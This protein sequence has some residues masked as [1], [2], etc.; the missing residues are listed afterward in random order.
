M[1]ENNLITSCVCDNQT[2][3]NFVVKNHLAINECKICGVMHQVLAGWSKENYFNFYK[4]DYHSSYQHKKGITPYNSRYDHDRKIAKIRLS[5]YKSFLNK[6]D[7][8]LD[9]GSSNSAFVHE[10]IEQN[11][12]SLGLEPGEDIGDSNV[13]VRGTL[14]TVAFEENSISV[15]TMHDSIEHIIDVNFALDKIY[16]ILK[17]NGILILDLPNYFV[18]AGKHH[19]KYIEHLW[20]FS[21]TQMEKI[22]NQHKFEIFQISEPIPGKLVFYSRKK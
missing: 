12:K 21:K 15:V 5:A 17:N 4:Q 6:D 16:S 11:F 19:W 13:T 18:E 7:F 22:M 8:I 1:I 10:C 2:Q 9:I 20:F 14:E 3:F